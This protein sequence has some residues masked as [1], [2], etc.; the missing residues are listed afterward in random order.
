M[1]ITSIQRLLLLQLLIRINEVGV[2]LVEVGVVLV[3][4]GVVE[5]EVG[6]ITVEV[7]VVIVEGSLPT[8][9]TIKPH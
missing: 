1:I 5:V 7:G 9:L 3:E 4:L 2:V 8:P 6:V